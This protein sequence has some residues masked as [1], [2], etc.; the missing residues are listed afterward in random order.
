MQIPPHATGKSGE[1]NLRDL[2][3]GLSPSLSKSFYVFVTIEHLEPAWPGDSDVLGIFKETEGVTIICTEDFANR[4]ELNFDERFRQITCE[5]H[6][7]LT[8][9]GLTAAISK[10]LA[11]HGISANVVAAYYHDHIFVPA[12]QASDAHQLLNRLSK[13][14]NS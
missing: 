8:A 5:V 4:H 1:V 10:Q 13:T 9:V 12:T 14:Q 6:S 11:N 2:L 3:R 7:S